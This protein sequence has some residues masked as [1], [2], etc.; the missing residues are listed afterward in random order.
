MADGKPELALQQFEKAAALDP[1]NPTIKARV[2]ISEINTGKAQEGLAQLEQVFASEAGATIAGPT[3]VLSELRA[4]RIKKAAEVAASL[5]KLDANNP[6]YQT[7]LG[8]VDVAQRDYPAAEAA[9]RA[10][11]A[12]NPEFVR[13]PAIWRSSMWRPGAPK[14]QKRSMA[15]FFQTR[16]TTLPPFSGWRISRSRRRNGPRRPVTLTA[17]APPRPNDPTPGIK[18]VNLYELRQDWKDALAV[19]GELVAQFPRDANVHIAQATAELGAGDTKGAIASLRPSTR[20]GARFD[21]NPVPLCQL[22]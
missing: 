8:M 14:T 15:S 20:F 21:A 4:R 22:C 5:I 19:A 3:L 17:R 10:A 7:L 11:L 16:P 18:L 9:F 1:E 12:R 13:P 6:L 2:A